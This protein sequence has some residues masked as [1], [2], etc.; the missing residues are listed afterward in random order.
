MAKKLVFMTEKEVM[1]AV[2]QTTGAT[3]SSL[4]FSEEWELDTIQIPV[5]SNSEQL[6]LILESF[7]DRK[8][9]QVTATEVIVPVESF[10]PTFST[11]L[12]TPLTGG[13]DVCEC[14]LFEDEILYAFTIA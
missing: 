14:N 13:F 10:I 2:N 1:E 4:G 3:S 7:T 8:H 9:I 11:L 6:N 12:E 5:S